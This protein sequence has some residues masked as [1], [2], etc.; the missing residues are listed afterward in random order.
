MENFGKFITIVLALIISPIISGFVLSKLWLWFI[1]ST[2]NANPIRIVEAIGIMF[3]INYILS[4]SKALEN[5]SEDNFWNK[6]IMAIFATII[7][8]A[9]VLLAG[10]IVKLFL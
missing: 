3:L 7:T 9:F 1:V 5:K 8:S 4:Q 10:W 2:F 6:F